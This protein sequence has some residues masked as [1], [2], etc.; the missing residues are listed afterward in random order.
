ML[1]RENTEA[2]ENTEENLYSNLYSV[3]S[4]VSV[5]SVIIHVRKEYLVS[6]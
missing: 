6:G 3:A 4:V 5:P 1:I 2:A